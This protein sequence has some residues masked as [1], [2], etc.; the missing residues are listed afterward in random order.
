MI[1][2]AFRGA[3]DAAL[4]MRTLWIA[5]GVNIVLDPCL[6]FGLGPFPEMGL[7][8][9]A[10]A[11]AIGRGIGIA[12][13]VAALVRGRG[14]IRVGREQLRLR[15]DVIVQLLRLSVGGTMQYLVAT[16]SWV[17]LVRIVGGFGAAAVAGYTIAIRIILFALLPSWGLAARRQR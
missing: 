13:Q 2:A 10:V 4:A 3:G 7:T 16:A 17:A 6:I 1:N 8:G 11:T 14:Q 12:Y 15:L 9:A 5:N